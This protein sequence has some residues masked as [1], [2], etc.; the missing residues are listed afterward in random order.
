[1]GGRK[2]HFRNPGGAARLQYIQGPGSIGPEI[3]LRIGKRFHHPR[4]SGQMYN[5][6]DSFGR[7]CQSGLISNVTYVQIHTERIDVLALSEAEVIEYADTRTLLNQARY[8]IDADKPAASGHQVRF[9]SIRPLRL[10]AQR[11]GRDS[12]CRRPDGLL[13]GNSQCHAIEWS[14]ARN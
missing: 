1:T 9:H 8:Q 2:N 12:G 11:S 6:I 10:K 4:M 5:D 7:F 13:E 3:Q 14:S